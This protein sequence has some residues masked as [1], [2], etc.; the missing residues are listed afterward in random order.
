MV[1]D[2]DNIVRKMVKGWKKSLTKQCEARIKLL[3]RG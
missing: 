3:R 1:E 2:K